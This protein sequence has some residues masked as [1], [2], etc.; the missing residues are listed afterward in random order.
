MPLSVTGDIPTTTDL[1]GKIVTDL[2]ENISV[3]VR[4][5]TGTLKYVTDYTGFSGNPDQQKGNYLALKVNCPVE[6]AAITVKLKNTTT[7]DEDRIIVL[8]VAEDSPDTI[9][10]T[11][12]AEGYNT[13]VQTYDISGL[14]KEEP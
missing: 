14:V 3:N 1:L 4:N 8:Y 6:N 2:Q 7:L 13:T 5:I 12:T 10:I 9:T 11:A